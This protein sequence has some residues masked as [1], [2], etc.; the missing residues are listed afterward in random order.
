MKKIAIAAAVMLLGSSGAW[1]LGTAAYTY[2]DNNASLS[3]SAGG[4]TYNVDADLDS[5][6]NTAADSFVVDRK[7]DMV[8]TNEDGDQISVNPSETAKVT[9]WKLTNE[10]NYDQNFSLDAVAQLNGDTVYGDADTRDTSTCTIYVD[11]SSFDTANDII[12][13]A[14]GADKNIEVH[15]DI[16]AK[17]NTAPNVKDGDVM[18]I[19]LT[20]HAV[21]DAYNK[22]LANDTSADDPNTVQIVLADSVSH[23]VGGT[24]KYGDT[25][26]T[27]DVAGN[28]TYK[29][30]GGYIVN[31]PELS[32]GKKSCV[33]SDPVNNTSNPKRIPGATVLYVID[34]Y[35]DSTSTDATITV[36]DNLVSY[37]D[38]STVSNVQTDINA[39]TTPCDC[40]DGS[41]YTV[42]GTAGTNS[43]SG[44]DPQV[45]VDSVEVGAKKHTCVTFEVEIK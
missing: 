3:Y 36:T 14:I 17:G 26:T 40:S 9:T 33:V 21:D 8:L 4:T 29:A 7:V 19:E 23:T 22:Y 44:S 15:C 20:T 32:L 18:N 13:L 10:S 16:P 38:Y 12:S 1:A 45:K 37:L 43:N 6:G 2:I 39:T 35:N 34:V 5:H 11:G 41:H 25:N 31:T 30:R 24:E 28:G 42:G 27:L